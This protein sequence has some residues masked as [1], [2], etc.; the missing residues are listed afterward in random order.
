MTFDRRAL[1]MAAGGVSTALIGAGQSLAA[2]ASVAPLAAAGLDPLMVYRKMYAGLGAG[3]ECCWWYGGTLPFQV[4]DIGLVEA[5]QEET[6]R[7]HR[8][9]DMGPDKFAIHWREAGV[10]RDFLTGEVPK[11]WFDPVTGVQAPH[12]STL[13]GGLADYVVSRSG[14]GITVELRLPGATVHSVTLDGAVKGD[15]VSLTQVE[16]KSRMMLGHASNLRTTLKIYASLAE[17]KSGA[18]SV[19][20]KGYYSVYLPDAQKVFVAGM[21]QKASVT[22]KL[23]PIAWDRVKAASPA[24]FKG[25][26][27]SP[28][29]T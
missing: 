15:R 29:W 8:V 17:L 16:T 6:L 22:E 28:D 21:M 11:T 25:D 26:R 19:A 4:E 1:L 9:E 24:F 2:E 7:A 27:V 18:P 12:D 20:A 10:F 13:G 23:N 3:A 5:F 14:S